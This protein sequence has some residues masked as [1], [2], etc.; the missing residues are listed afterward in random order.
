M[1]MNTSLFLTAG[2]FPTQSRLFSTQRQAYEEMKEGMS[3]Q[4]AAFYGDYFHDYNKG[5]IQL[6]ESTSTKELRDDNDVRNIF[7]GLLEKDVRLLP[8]ESRNPVV[9]QCIHFL[10]QYLPI[11]VSDWLKL[12]LMKPPK[13]ISKEYPPTPN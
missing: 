5:L 11:R 1:K 9:L 7:L 4:D 6:F 8:V 12:R 10:F 3:P 2:N 13:W